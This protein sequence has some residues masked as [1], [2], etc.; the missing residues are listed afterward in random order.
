VAVVLPVTRQLP[1]EHAMQVAL[2]VKTALRPSEYV[3][4]GHLLAATV[5][6]PVPGGQ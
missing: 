1:R 5:A 3:P 4:R 2:L 6:A